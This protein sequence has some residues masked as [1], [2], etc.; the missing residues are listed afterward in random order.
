M[1]LDSLLC[2]NQIAQ[3][4]F[5][6]KGVNIL[7][8][9]LR[10]LSGLTEYVIIAEGSAYKHV[11]AI[12]KGVIDEM[13]KLGLKPLY[14]EGMRDGEWVALDFSSIVVHLFLPDWREKYQL[15]SLWKLAEIV[16][17]HID[18]SHPISKSAL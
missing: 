16:D 18:T 6:K 5:D 17:V 15:E 14:V 1:A 3:A 7:A 11:I 4:I 13:E 2:L 12:A 8:L 9:D 10:P